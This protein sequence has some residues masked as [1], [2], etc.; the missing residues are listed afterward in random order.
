MRQTDTGNVQDRNQRRKSVVEYKFTMHK[1]LGV[2]PHTTM[3]Y[4][5][6]MY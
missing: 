5:I 6:H 2:I 3:N 1:A 4:Y